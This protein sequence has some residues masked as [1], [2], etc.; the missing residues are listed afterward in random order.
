[1]RKGAL[2]RGFALVTVAM[3][4][5]CSAPAS[6][7][8]ASSAAPE[9]TIA[10]ATTTPRA[11]V[12]PAATCKECWPLTGKPARLGAVDKRPLLIKIDNVPAARPHYGITQA[13]MVF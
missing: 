10:A 4:V 7:T 6:T 9:S 2:A 1:M 11:S 8:P 12:D 13:D 5:A 3:L